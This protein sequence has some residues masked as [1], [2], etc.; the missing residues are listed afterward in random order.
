MKTSVMTAQG[1]FIQQLMG[2]ASASRVGN[3]LPITHGHLNLL[4][5]LSGPLPQSSNN[6]DDDNH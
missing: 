1:R 6:K 2:E 5:S 3:Y 4:A